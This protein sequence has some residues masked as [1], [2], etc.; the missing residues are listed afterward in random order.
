VGTTTSLGADG[1]EKV[2]G[3]PAYSLVNLVLG[4][5]QYAPSIVKGT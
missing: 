4:V 2:P 5:L 1:E 3:R